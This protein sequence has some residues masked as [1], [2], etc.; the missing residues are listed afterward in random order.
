MRST[1]IPA[2]FASIVFLAVGCGNPATVPITSSQPS[3]SCTPS[4]TPEYGYL[5]NSFNG[6]TVYMY[7]VD[8]CTGALVSNSP[9]SI[10]TGY[11]DGQGAE[12]MVTDPL[13]RFVYVANLVSNASDQAT[14]T[15]FTA[16][17]KTGVLTPTSPATVPTGFFPQGIAIDPMG[18]FVYTADSD[19]NA[20]SMFTINQSTGVLTPTSPA[21][22]STDSYDFR[23]LDSSPAAVAVDPSGRF[24][25]AV[26][27]DQG[28]VSMFSI[29]QN[30]GLLTPTSP[31][32]VYTGPVPFSIAISPNGKFA[33]V[34]NNDSGGDMT[35]GISQYTIDPTTGVLTQNSPPAVAAGNQ[36]TA[37]VVDPTSK[38]AYV[39]NRYDNTVSMYTI[40]P[41][42]GNL[43]ANGTVAVGSM[44]FRIL[45]DSTG[46]FLYVVNEGGPASVFTVKTDGTLAATQV[47]M[48]GT[49]S[50]SIA[51][52]A[53]Q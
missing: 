34:P 12:Q 11:A 27:E 50:L 45:F 17:P 7:T 20:L 24:V 47:G 6:T 9:G 41:T 46:K 31:A 30:T 15:M 21:E 16:D 53:A 43:T 36:P 35:Y 25:Y 8:S 18:R 22:V 39:V 4:T 3:S 1:W 13:G 14:I 51:F 26:N 23:G 40:D 10:S 2:A 42:T 28:S 38:F 44:P 19:D 33:Y 32:Y 37:V 29:D 48:T 52:T 49:D 5:L